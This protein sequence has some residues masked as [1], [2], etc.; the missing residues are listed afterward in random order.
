[1]PVDLP[2]WLAAHREW[3]LA[4]CVCGSGRCLPYRTALA[5]KQ[6]DSRERVI[7][8]IYQPQIDFA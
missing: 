2:C 4:C 7:G 6:S 3:R 5:E 8:R 1:V